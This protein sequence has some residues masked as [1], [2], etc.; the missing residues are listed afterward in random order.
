MLPVAK[1]SEGRV[2]CVE[3][4]V[5]GCDSSMGGLL[6]RPLKLNLPPSIGSSPETMA[7]MS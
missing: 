3:R 4:V 1:A 2:F 6:L 5:V 7:A